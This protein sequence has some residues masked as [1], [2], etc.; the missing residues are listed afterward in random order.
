MFGQYEALRK[1]RLA[2]A[3]AISRRVSSLTHEQFDMS[4]DSNWG[5]EIAAER[6]AASES[7][8]QE[9]ISSSRRRG[10]L[11][12]ACAMLLRFKDIVSSCGHLQRPYLSTKTDLIDRHNSVVLTI[13]L[14]H[15][16]DTRI[17][18][19]F[20]SWRCRKLSWF[21]GTSWI[22]FPRVASFTFNLFNK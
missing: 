11:S 9:P 3:R 21:M 13:K 19:H 8:W 1:W 18:R 5:H 14:L 16:T 15:L 4:R 2:Q 7:L 6:T 17:T 20:V 12:T 10:Q 22:P